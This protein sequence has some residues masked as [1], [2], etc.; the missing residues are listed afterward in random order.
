MDSL[1]LPMCYG[2]FPGN[3]NDCLTL[4]PMVQKYNKKNSYGASKYVK[5]LVF[6]EK[7]GEIIKAKS[8]FT[9]FHKYLFNLYA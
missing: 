8:N 3:T 9:F 2:L 5:H 4:K 6:D 1:G 7:N